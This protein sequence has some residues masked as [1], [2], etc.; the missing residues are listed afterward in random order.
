MIFTQTGGQSAAV[1]RQFLRAHQH[2]TSS[3]NQRTRYSLSVVSLT[4]LYRVQHDAVQ[5]HPVSHNTSVT[6][7]TYFTYTLSLPVDHQ[8][9]DH[10][11]PSSSVFCCC[12]RLLTPD[13]FLQI[14]LRNVFLGCPLLCGLTVSSVH[15]PQAVV[16][17]GGGALVSINRV[18]TRQA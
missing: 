16:W 7:L 11:S 10:L 14:S 12:F 9:T 3:Q 5:Y 15:C 17:H 6:A 8:T 13:F 1:Q 4:L 18:K 2:R